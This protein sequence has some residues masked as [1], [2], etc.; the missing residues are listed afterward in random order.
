MKDEQFNKN[1]EKMLNRFDEID[2]EIK[3][4]IEKE[5]PNDLDCYDTGKTLIDNKYSPMRNYK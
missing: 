1:L 5:K 3:Q 2:R 4:I